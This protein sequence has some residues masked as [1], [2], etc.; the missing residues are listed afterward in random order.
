M[1]NDRGSICCHLSLER[2]NFFFFLEDRIATNYL[3]PTRHFKISRMGP[4]V[5]EGASISC[6]TLH[7]WHSL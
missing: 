7:P 6:F 4:G 2:V 3:D 1:K 5:C